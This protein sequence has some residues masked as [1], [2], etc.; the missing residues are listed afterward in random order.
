MPCGSKEIKIATNK[1]T[2]MSLKK[3]FSNFSYKIFFMHLNVLINMIRIRNKVCISLHGVLDSKAAS[4]L[5]KKPST[6]QLRRKIF[7]D[8]EHY[9]HMIGDILKT[10]L[11]FKPDLH[12]IC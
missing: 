5:R 3:I 6:V 9:G 8:G 10:K 11:F 7:F 1:I 12:K 4:G 2:P